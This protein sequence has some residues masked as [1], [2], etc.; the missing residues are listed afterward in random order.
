MATEHKN[1]LIEVGNIAFWSNDFKRAKV[2]KIRHWFE[3]NGYI[4]QVVLQ[5]G[6]K[7]RTKEFTEYGAGVTLKKICDIIQ[8]PKN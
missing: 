5:N 3:S 4:V 6:E 8:T 1:I 7:I 2:K